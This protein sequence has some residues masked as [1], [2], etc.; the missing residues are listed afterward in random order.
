MLRIGMI[1]QKKSVSERKS[2]LTKNRKD[3]FIFS[4]FVSLLFLHIYDRL[5]DHLIK[6]LLL[7]IIITSN[8]EVNY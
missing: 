5:V 2:L 7:F 1:I 8:V 3:A 4:I 6:Y